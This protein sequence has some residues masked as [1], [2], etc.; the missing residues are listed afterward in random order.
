MVGALGRRHQIFSMIPLKKNSRE[1]FL[2]LNFFETWC[3]EVS[4]ILREDETMV[5]KYEG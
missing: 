5:P 1:K 4:K 3:K 2:N